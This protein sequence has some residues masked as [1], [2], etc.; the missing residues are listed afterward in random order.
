MPNRSHTFRTGSCTRIFSLSMVMPTPEA[1]A[2]SNSPP[3][4]PH[5][6]ASCIEV[7][8]SSRTPAST[9]VRASSTTDICQKISSASRATFSPYRAATRSDADHGG[10]PD[11]RVLASFV[12]PGVSGDDRH[13]DLLALPV[14]HRPERLE[15]LPGHGEGKVQV[16]GDV[17]RPDP[18]GDRV[19]GQDVHGEPPR[20][21]PSVGGYHEDRVGGRH[22]HLAVPQ[23]DDPHVHPVPRP[24]QDF[25]PLPPQVRKDDFVEDVGGYLPDD[26]H[27]R[28]HAA[29]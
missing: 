22:H 17:A 13:A 4:T 21:F 15:F 23:V 7:T 29:L 8:P 19:G 26:G 27:L 14:H 1:R 20:S 18:G 12:A 5:S 11:H 6:V 25:G 10:A 28:F 16:H 3:Q 2:T 9:A 24:H